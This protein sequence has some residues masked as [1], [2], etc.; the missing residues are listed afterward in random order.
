MGKKK[1]TTLSFKIIQE[2]ELMTGLNSATS[3]ILSIIS[4]AWQYVGQEKKF[5]KSYRQLCTQK[6]PILPEITLWSS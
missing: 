3:T 1:N 6:V 5:L 2:K 4:I